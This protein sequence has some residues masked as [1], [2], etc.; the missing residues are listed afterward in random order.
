MAGYPGARWAYYVCEAMDSAFHGNIFY[1]MY[2]PAN[3]FATPPPF[4][5]GPNVYHA[6][7]VYAGELDLDR[8]VMEPAH[9]NDNDGVQGQTPGLLQTQAA[10]Q[11]AAPAQLS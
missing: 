4:F 11:A 5:P 2:G 7:S 8:A 1:L 10:V 9:E 6:M 3:T